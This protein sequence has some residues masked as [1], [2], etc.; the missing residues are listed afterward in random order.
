MKNKFLCVILCLCLLSGVFVF[1][2]CKK[3]DGYQLANLYNDYL[4]IAK[5]CRAVQFNNGRLEFYYSNFKNAEDDYYL[6][7]AINNSASPYNNLN[8]FNTIF[9]NSMLF[10]NQNVQ[11]L[12]TNLFKVDK[13]LRNRLSSNL[14]DLN[15]AVK[16][17]DLQTQEFARNIITNE[18]DLNNQ[19]YLITFEHLLNSYEELFDVCHELNLT[20]ASVYYS[21]ANTNEDVDFSGV[22]AQSL[23]DLNI[24]EY[25]GNL[26]NRANLSIA[27]LSFRFYEQNIENGVL[28]SQIVDNS[29]GNFGTMGEEYNN[30]L[31]QVRAISNSTPNTSNVN[32]QQFYNCI[33]QLYNVRE[34]LKNDYESY[35]KALHGINYK[36]VKNFFNKT[37]YE[38]FCLKIINHYNYL[39]EQNYLAIKAAYDAL[40]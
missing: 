18:N 27:F 40:K 28:S 4:A 17:I 6:Q 24:E 31:A 3:D 36:D 14:T 25:V 13:T 21:V 16:K 7:N 12:S 2:A 1:S 35:Y 22:E 29:S 26:K 32:K 10:F 37:D 15:T 20:F 11:S 38:I 23:T 39:Q 9:Y 33:L 19:L 5:D 8:S 30:Y 34:S